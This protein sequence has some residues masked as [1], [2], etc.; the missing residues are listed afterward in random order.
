MAYAEPGGGNTFIA[1]HQ[2]TGNLVVEYSRNP[3]SYP[4]LRYSEIRPVQKTRGLWAK[5]DPTQGGR[6]RFADGRDFAWPPGADS[7][8]GRDNLSQFTFVQYACN[9]FAPTTMLEDR[10]I[11]QSS[12]DVAEV[13]LRKLGMETMTLRTRKALAALSGAAWDASNTLA[14]GSIS[15]VS[16]NWGNGTGAQPNI[17]ISIQ[18]AIL[19]ILQ[20]SVGTVTPKDLVMVMG[21]D[22]AYKLSQSPEVRGILSNSVWAYPLLTNTLPGTGGTMNYALPPMLYG[23]RIVVDDTVIVTSTKGA[24]TT[25]TGFA[26]PAGVVYIVARAENEMINPTILRAESGEV[27]MTEDQRSAVPIYSTLTMFAFEEMTTENN[28]DTWNRRTQIRVTSDYDFQITSLAGA[29]KFT[30]A[31]G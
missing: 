9:R 28:V 25:T 30:A 19:Q 29:Y 15:G 17:E 24:A 8:N 11:G 4:L 26:V 7:P 12:W 13:E 14:V 5:I 6:V 10:S 18:Y 20:A 31:L 16:G 27:K 1:D 21:P 22:T 3:K 2:A 23:V